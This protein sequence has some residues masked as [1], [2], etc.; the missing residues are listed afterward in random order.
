MIFHIVVLYGSCAA[1]LF[2][3]AITPGDARRPWLLALAPIVALGVLESLLLTIKGHL[4]LQWLFPLATLAAVLRFSR[5]DVVARWSR[6][7]LPAVALGLMIHAHYLM[8]H[9]Y[10]TSRPFA[11]A[12]GE[13]IESAWYTPLTG[14]AKVAH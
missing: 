10:S 6:R 11:L 14:L 12:P 3:T 7:A 4:V 1:A 2:A 13:R 9:G 5:S 8:G